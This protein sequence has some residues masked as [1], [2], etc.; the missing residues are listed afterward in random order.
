MAARIFVKRP[1]NPPKILFYGCCAICEK[2][3]SVTLEWKCDC[4]SGKIWEKLKRKDHAKK[5]KKSKR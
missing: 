2:T 4:D 5:Q 1:K 3:N